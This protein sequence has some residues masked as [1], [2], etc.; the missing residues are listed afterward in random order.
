MPE[1][2]RAAIATPRPAATILLLRDDPG[3]I[4][5]FMQ[6]RHQDMKFASGAL[7][8]P[9]GASIPRTT[10]WPWMPHYRRRRRGLIH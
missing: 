3:G 2:E 5:V 7:V 1:P 9:G 8:F 6:V 4:E 10:R